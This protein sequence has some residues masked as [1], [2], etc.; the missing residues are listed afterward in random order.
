M[1]SQISPSSDARDLR[2]A[3][4]VSRYHER[5]T[6]AMRDAAV[7]RFLGAGG[8]EEDLLIVPAAGSFELTAVCDAA[9]ARPGIHAVVAIGCVIT[10]ET[11]HDRY[12]CRAIA[13]GLTEVSLRRS[14]PV[15]FG[16]LTCQTMEQAE[17]RAGGAVGNKGDEAMAAAIETA[18]TVQSL[19]RVKPGRPPQ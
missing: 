11:R 15:A 5:I 12:I 3:V 9:A 10:G 19:S 14:V 7:A 1:K 8:R 6:S 2:V 13:H 17:A 16:V 18:R 4:V